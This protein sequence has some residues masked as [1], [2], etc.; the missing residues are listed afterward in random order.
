MDLALLHCSRGGHPAAREPHAAQ[1]GYE[2]GLAQNCKVTYLKHYEILCVCMITC[3]NVFNVWTKTT[4][5]L[6][7]WP[8]DSKRVDTL[9]QRISRLP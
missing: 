8:R 4:L 2:R 7:V 5:L 9:L 1:D 6:P 3:R